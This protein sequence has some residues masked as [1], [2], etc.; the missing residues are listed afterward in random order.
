MVSVFPG[1]SH[2]VGGLDREGALR[3]LGAK[4]SVQGRKTKVYPDEF[5]T[6]TIEGQFGDH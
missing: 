6:I 1:P 2:P 4:L 3:T 5:R